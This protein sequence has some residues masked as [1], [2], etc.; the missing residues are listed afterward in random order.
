MKTKSVT[1]YVYLSYLAGF[2]GYE[3]IASLLYTY[4]IVPLREEEYC[5]LLDSIADKEGHSVRDQL[6][7]IWIPAYLV[8]PR[9][10]RHSVRLTSYWRQ[11]RHAV[12]GKS[13]IIYPGTSKVWEPLLQDRVAQAR[14]EGQDKEW[15]IEQI[16]DH[17]TSTFL[18]G[19]AELAL[20]LADARASLDFVRRFPCP[21]MAHPEGVQFLATMSSK[22]IKE[23]LGIG[24]T[25]FMLR[26]IPDFNRLTYRQILEGRAT[27]H[28]H[29]F[30]KWLG[31][32][33]WAIEHKEDLAQRA[34]EEMYKSSLRLAQEVEP[35]MGWAML[36]GLISA[37][38]VPYVNPASFVLS[39]VEIVKLRRLAR[40]YGHVFFWASLANDDHAQDVARK[41]SSVWPL[42]TYNVPKSKLLQDVQMVNGA[43]S[44]SPFY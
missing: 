34:H 8:R 41:R 15:D 13:E 22:D 32:L 27:P 26:E 7:D 16:L 17:E 19:R 33:V 18:M 36:K 4:V 6:R 40:K 38:P 37:A 31:H 35:K 1:E 20:A 39:G 14:R 5:E 21:V 25:E 10:D 28:W 23:T 42:L 29:S 24:F 44:I 9:L 12:G 3:K 2:W 30:R 11:M 43:D